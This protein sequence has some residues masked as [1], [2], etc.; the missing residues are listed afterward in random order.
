MLQGFIALIFC[1]IEHFITSFLKKTILKQKSDEAMIHI[2][3]I[4]K[5]LK[6]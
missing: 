4:K 6:F 3:N 1:H 2:G 5:T